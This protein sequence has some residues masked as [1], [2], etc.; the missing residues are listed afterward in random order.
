M[1]GSWCF[2]LS[3]LGTT[4]QWCDLMGD[5][6]GSSRLPVDSGQWRAEVEVGRPR[7]R[8]LPQSSLEGD[9]GPGRGWWMLDTTRKRKQETR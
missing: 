4:D 3:R 1:S 2:V 8:P 6:M 9:A 7:R 5:P